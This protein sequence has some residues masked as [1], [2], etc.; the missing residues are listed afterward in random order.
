MASTLNHARAKQNLGAADK[1]LASKEMRLTG[2]R[3][4]EESHP[5]DQARV[6]PRVQKQASLG[7][8]ATLTLAPREAF[9]AKT[10]RNVAA[11]HWLNQTEPKPTQHM[12]NA[13]LYV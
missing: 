2:F 7:A 11:R 13:S 5:H 1:T 9:L 3:A 4:L 8:E 6:S 12:R 10:S